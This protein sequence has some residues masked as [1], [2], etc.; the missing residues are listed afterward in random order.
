MAFFK[1]RK[2]ADD[3]PRPSGPSPSIEAIRQRAKYRLAGA[4]VLVL[5]AVIGL[6]LL[7]DK[8]P[9]P[10]AVDTPIVIPDKNKVS[11]LVIPPSPVKPA[12]IDTA[13]PPAAAV[14][15]DKPVTEPAPVVTEKPVVADKPAPAP[16]PAAAPAQKPAVAKIAEEKQAPAHADKG[17][18][19]TNSVVKEAPA[20]AKPA[21]SKP[22]ANRA[23]A[24]LEGKADVKPANKPTDTSAKP[25]KATT[26]AAP[27][28]KPDNSGEGRFVVQVGAFADNVRA[29]EARV[30][31]EAAGIKTYVQSADTKDGRRIRVRAGPFASKAEADKVA[32]KIKKLNLPAAL[33][34]L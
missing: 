24:L 30:K 13:V 14:V 7:F 8:Q 12:S 19:A 31:L 4:T 11:P 32:E 15:A 27:S 9:R 22:D 26:P 2:G 34:T 3:S 10:I 21:A 25:A 29:H 1:F 23:L 6:P 5:V 28:A 16:H 20:S 17:H 18:S 33:L